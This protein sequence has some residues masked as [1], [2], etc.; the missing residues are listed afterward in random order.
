MSATIIVYSPKGQPEKHTRAN[1]RDLVNG[2]GYSWHPH[3]PATPASYAPFAGAIPPEGPP[4]SQKVLDSVGGSASGGNS[5]AQA[6]AAAQAEEQRRIQAALAA[7]ASVAPPPAVEVVDYSAPQAVDVSDLDDDPEDEADA[8]PEFVS[9]P[10]QA[11]E[12]EAVP[13]AVVAAPAL[14][15][16]PRGRGGR[17]PRA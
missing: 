17:K 6:A 10:E 8:A 9:E 5:A 16:V 12:V 1:A 2:A 11:P 13:E 7:Q 15:E 4:P 3:V 14:T